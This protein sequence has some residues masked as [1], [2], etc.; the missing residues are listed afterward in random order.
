MKQVLYM[1]LRSK[2]FQN[3]LWRFWQVMV[4]QGTSF[5]I[6][7]L[8]SA[9]LSP[10]EFGTYNYILAIVSLILIFSDFGISI[11]TSKYIAE[12]GE[13]GKDKVPFVLF[14]ALLLI[15]SLSSITSLAVV[16][17]G[18]PL[19]KDNYQFIVYLLPILFL[20]PI[21]SIYDGIYRSIGRF[22]KLALITTVVG[23]LS[24][25]ISYVFVRNYGLKGA[26][27]SQSI[28]NLLLLLF[29]AVGFTE[30]KFVFKKEIIREIGKYAL[31]LGLAGVGSF[32]FSRIDV[33]FL[34]HYNYIEEI[35][36]Y[37][38]IF[39][40]L[41]LILLPFYTLSQ[42]LAPDIT[43][44]Y[45]RGE[46]QAVKSKF[47]LYLKFTF[48]SALCI[49]FTLFLGQSLLFEVFLNKYNVPEMRNMFAAMIVVFFT[50]ILVSIIPTAFT[51]ATGYAK[52]NMYFLMVFGSLNVV[53][54][55]IFI[56]IWGAIGI[57]YA[58]VVSKTLSDISFIVVSYLVGIKP[59]ISHYNKSQ[60][61]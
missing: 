21:N 8:V 48:V 22:R 36:Y 37:E 7:F 39:K 33:L 38:I 30:V 52:L 57:I 2:T 9:L 55:F 26:V 29:Q 15:I 41:T 12:Y 53:L 47:I 49:A 6:F 56:R 20:A 59:K 5:V 60:A 50:Q 1:K 58:T 16:L 13:I 31:V 10:V 43:R 40:I 27:I 18:K 3:I 28:F 61:H 23:S 34:G 54:D 45:V 17:F 51:T 32:L 4:K 35:G 11:A 14:N 24:L 19:F 46:Y 42:V 44:L 25:L